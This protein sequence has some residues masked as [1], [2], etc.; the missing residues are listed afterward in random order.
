LRLK[1]DEFW[2]LTLSEFTE[3]VDAYIQDETDRQ[4]REYQ[5]IAWLAS[6]LMN[7]MGT[8]KRP[9]T[10]DR[11]L[12]KRPIQTTRPM[13]PEER[14]KALEELKKKFESQGGS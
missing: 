8:L 3:M 5:K 2:S 6:N 9:V 14:E 10:V 1:P 4:E 7:A 12:G 13:T 11:L